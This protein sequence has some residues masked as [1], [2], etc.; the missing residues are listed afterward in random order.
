MKTSHKYPLFFYAPD[1]DTIAGGAAT[2]EVPEIASPVSTPKVEP[3][4]LPVSKGPISAA[5]K[6][7]LAVPGIQGPKEAGFHEAEDAGLGTKPDRERDDKGKFVPLS[8][9]TAVKETLKPKVEA[10]PVVKPVAVK[11]VPVVAKF[12]IGDKEMT[13]EEITK[14]VADLEA[15]AN[16]KTPE[17]EKPVD[18]AK[19]PSE[20]DKQRQDDEFYTRAGERYKPTEDE[21]DAILSGGPEAAVNLSRTLA[22]VELSTRK[23]VEESVNP[24]IA[25]LREQIQP[26]L[27]QQKQIQQYTTENQFLSANPDIKDHPQG[28]EQSRKIESALH[29]KRERVERLIRAG[30]A[31]ESELSFARTFDSMTPEDFQS[32]VAFHTRAALK[33]I[34]SQAPVVTPPA[35]APIAPT[36]PVAARDTPFNGERPGGHSTPGVES[37]QARAI[38]EMGNRGM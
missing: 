5:N 13:Q 11:P 35:A 38:R 6:L 14:H 23:W 25:S 2:L 36:P 24:I 32:D 27:N 18:V 7:G 33:A 3:V 9:K 26:L 21:L 20:E 16:P 28:L 17:P 1:G 19:T 34:A 10:K 37:D 8:E 31:N 22:K 4:I 12:K 15:K 29:E 30:A